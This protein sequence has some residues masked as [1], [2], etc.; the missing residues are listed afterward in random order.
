MMLIMSFLDVIVFAILSNSTFMAIFMSIDLNNYIT[1]YLL[2][3]LRK[4]I[5]HRNVR[6]MPVCDLKQ[7]YGCQHRHY[8]ENVFDAKNL[9][10]RL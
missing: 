10:G 8:A 9:G 1:P 6:T 7:H 5:I 2:A 3:M 4:S